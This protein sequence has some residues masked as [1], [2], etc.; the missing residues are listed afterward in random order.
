MDFLFLVGRILFAVLFL[1]SGFAHFKAVDAM[2]GYAQFKKVPA[3]RASVLLSGAVLILGGLSV[4]LGFHGEWGSLL[5]VLFLVPTAFLMHNF[6]TV[7][8]AQAKMT[9]QV[10]FNKDIA[11]AGAALVLFWVFSTVADLPLILTK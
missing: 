4:L 7:E 5:L 3:A 2:T 9:E 8:D 11:L 6:W 10:A 1:G